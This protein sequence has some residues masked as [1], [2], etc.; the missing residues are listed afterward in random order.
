MD[1]SNPFFHRGPIRDPA[2]FFGRERE[3]SHILALLRN[4]QSVAIVG[5]RRIG[6]SS[7][8][9]QIANPT[10]FAAHGLN[11]ND[12]SFVY[13]D[14][15]S[16]NSYT[17]GDCYA[18]L[19]DELRQTL[20]AA[21]Y[22][23]AASAESATYRVFDQV[24]RT[25][26]QQQRQIIFLLDEFESL[27]KS[28]TLDIDL[29]SGLRSLS[30]RYH[31]AY[32]TVSTRPL[33]ELTYMR[34]NLL[35]SPFFNFFAQ[36]R[37]PLFASADYLAL[38]TELPMRNGVLF[39]PSIIEH[40][41]DLA[42]PHPLLLQIAGYYTFE[43]LCETGQPLTERDTELIQRR[44]HDEAEGHWD[45]F[46]RT[47]SLEDQRL[48]ALLPVDGQ[49]N[50]MG[51]QRLERA[52]L[53]VASDSAPIAPLSPAF[54]AFVARQQI[55]D[56]AQAPPVTLDPTRQIALVR[57]QPLTL[58]RAEFDLLACLVKRAGHVV[59][60]AELEAHVW[61]SEGPTDPER[62]KNTLKALRKSLG[63]AGECIQNVRGVG[64]TF[65]SR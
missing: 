30:T 35:S 13:V 22:E 55:P 33:L 18:S 6:K 31:V 17:A 12:Y 20:A 50:P 10:V 48:L 54:R 21:G 58:P 49:R 34:S 25:I 28:P 36:V 42:G 29:F 39:A 26:A 52:G 7:L 60:H 8:L 11:V 1:V 64:Y 56:L 5:P 14:C 38:L 63:A 2:Y 45:Y 40:I 19:I 32:V 44:F 24:I 51:V 65:V 53:I 9:R 57:H 27:S 41:L 23:I 47:L 46:W 4:A 61:P 59:P 15:N 62:L 3:V 37:I 16:W 43:R